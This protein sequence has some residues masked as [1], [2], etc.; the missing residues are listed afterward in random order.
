MNSMKRRCLASVYFVAMTSA[1]HTVLFGQAAPNSATKGTEITTKRLVVNGRAVPSMVVRIDNRLYVSLEDLSSAL[2]VAV[3][4]KGDDVIVSFSSEQPI[5]GSA[6]ESRTGVIRG[7]LT[8]FFN[9]NYG[10]RPDTGA[11][12]ALVAGKLDVPSTVNVFV[13]AS[14]REVTIGGKIVMAVKATTADGSGNYSLQDV[15]PG[16]YT[17]LLKS[18]HAKSTTQRD[19]AGKILTVPLT[20]KSGETVDMSEDFGM[21]Q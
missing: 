5:P 17:L 6:V 16:E 3:T 18:N 1:G 8:Y 9:S 10:N 21:S 4:L 14:S 7:T 20:V 2:N 12:V 19:I 11:V 13:Y 15:P